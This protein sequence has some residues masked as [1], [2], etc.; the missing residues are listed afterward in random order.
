LRPL[1][2]HRK[3]QVSYNDYNGLV[4][5][6]HRLTAYRC[7]KHTKDIP[8]KNNNNNNHNNHNGKGSFLK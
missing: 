6:V 1:Q 5:S 8:K 7:Q 4:A 3:S 2:Q